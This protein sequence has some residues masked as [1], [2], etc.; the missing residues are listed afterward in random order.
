MA[1]ALEQKSFPSTPETVSRGQR[2]LRTPPIPGDDEFQLDESLRIEPLRVSPKNAPMRAKSLPT[3]ETHARISASESILSGGSEWSATTVNTTSPS[4]NDQLKRSMSHNY[5]VRRTGSCASESRHLRMPSSESAQLGIHPAL[6][7]E[8]FFDD[9][10]ESPASGLDNTTVTNAV[11]TAMQQLQQVRIRDSILRPLRYEPRNKLHGPD[12]QLMSIF[13]AL[14][15]DELRIKRL[16][17]SD[18]LRVAVWWLLKV[19]WIL[20]YS[21]IILES[22]DD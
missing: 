1:D 7:E 11:A 20:Y 19:R 22:D 21:S 14:V 18:W 13:D 16:N 9:R 10:T 6:Q 4:I 17:T 8:P 2:V 12:P 15:Q 3:A 5:V